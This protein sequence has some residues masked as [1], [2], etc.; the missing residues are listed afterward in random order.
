[1]IDVSDGLAADLEHLVHASGVGVAIDD[2]PVAEGATP[3]QAMAGGEDYE[4]LFTLPPAAAAPPGALR[5]GTCTAD[6][7]ERT[8][9]GEPLP[10]APG[11][12]HSF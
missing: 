8:L 7:T 3:E 2:V 9:R 6:P 4:L 12:E 10:P 11:F 1:M 5:I